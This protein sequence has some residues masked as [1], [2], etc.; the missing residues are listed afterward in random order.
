MVVVGHHISKELLFSQLLKY[1]LPSL[2]VGELLSLPLLTLLRVILGLEPLEE[3]SC[4]AV[5]VFDAGRSNFLFTYIRLRN[6]PSN[7]IS[8]YIM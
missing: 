8:R 1:L 7:I 4:F 3:P 2:E 5:P 6:D